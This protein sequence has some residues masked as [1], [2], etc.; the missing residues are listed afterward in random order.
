M[1]PR[2]LPVEC[3]DYG[4]S[5]AAPG[6]PKSPASRR[7]LAPELNAPEPGSPLIC[8]RYPGSDEMR[9]GRPFVGQAGQQLDRMLAAAGI[10]RNRVNVTNVVSTQPAGNQFSAHRAADVERGLAELSELIVRLQPSIVV[11]MGNE[12]SWAC[13]G[14]WPGHRDREGRLSRG[15]IYGARDIQKRRGYLWGPAEHTLGGVKVL[16][17]LHPSAVMRDVSGITEMLVT[18]DLEKAWVQRDS[19]VLTRPPM[20]IKII[21]DDMQARDALDVLS[22]A[23][24]PVACDIEITRTW[25]HGVLCVG[26]ATAADRAYVFT[27]RMLHHAYWLLRRPTLQTVWQNGQ[28]DLHFLSTRAS[29]DVAGHLDDIIVAWHT[30]WPEIAGAAL[31]ADGDKRGSKATRKANEYRY[32]AD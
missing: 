32:V 22:N 4:L 1:G 27:P 17:T 12:A 16:T 18:L 8:G 11:A 23:S 13:V 15:S 30:R 20:R 7:W 5:R 25:P 19:P 9:T 2:L 6:D 29:V 21:R 31:D 3:L 10:N 24:S 14:D 26:F 28:F